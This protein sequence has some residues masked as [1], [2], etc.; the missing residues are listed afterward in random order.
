MEAVVLGGLRALNL[1]LSHSPKA[2]SELLSEDPLNNICIYYLL[3]Q[4]VK[5]I[6]SVS[7][8]RDF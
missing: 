5:Y 3:F 6:S 2:V 7:S 8:Y 4:C 1:Q